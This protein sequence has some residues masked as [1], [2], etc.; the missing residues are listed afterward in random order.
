M[1]AEGPATCL[2]D[3]LC[4]SLHVAA[5]L[6]LEGLP[7]ACVAARAASLVI[8]YKVIPLESTLTWDQFWGTGGNFFF[9]DT[10]LFFYLKI[11]VSC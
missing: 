6:N 3:E 10:F 2:C 5:A 9:L 8:Q 7:S 11:S 4:V 1:R